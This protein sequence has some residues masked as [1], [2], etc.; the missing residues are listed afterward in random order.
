MAHEVAQGGLPE[1][2]HHQGLYY[3][4]SSCEDRSEE[5]DCHGH[6]EQLHEQRR[7]L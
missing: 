7:R 6:R 2:H 3:T 5:L 1:F 4:T